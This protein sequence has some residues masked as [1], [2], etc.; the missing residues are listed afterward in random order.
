MGA[1]LP[2]TIACGD[3]SRK[4]LQGEDYCRSVVDG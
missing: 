4:P 2:A 3:F 1:R